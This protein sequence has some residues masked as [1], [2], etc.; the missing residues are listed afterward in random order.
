M[1]EGIVK[2]SVVGAITVPDSPAGIDMLAEKF[3]DV[4]HMEDVE[5][6]IKAFEEQ[7]ELLKKAAEYGSL[8]ARYA[9]LEAATY[10][11]LSRKG[12]SKALGAPNKMRR[13]AAEW[14]A[15]QEPAV[16]EMVING[17][18]TAKYSDLIDA[19]RQIQG[20]H[21]IRNAYKTAV[22]LKHDCVESFKQAG[23]VSVFSVWDH[24]V[25]ISDPHHD[26]TGE[27]SDN[28]SELD[29]FT[30]WVSRSLMQGQVGY[31]TEQMLDEIAAM[32]R[33][34]TRIA[35]RKAG[36]VG[37]G[38]GKYVDPCKYPE[39]VSKAIG[40]RKANVTACV[41]S[42]MALC[43]DAGVDFEHELA[44]ALS[45]VGWSKEKIVASID[46]TVG[47]VAA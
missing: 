10:C 36:A 4:M 22:N 46:R 42:L 32:A 34:S 16:Y 13:Q 7:D 28:D 31:R 43:K 5:N 2:A 41:M 29:C 9:S 44:E 45:M 18:L 20:E 1:G 39:E 37:I 23:M 6:V 26:P 25:C 24:G 15:A 21:A 8:R 33:D 30:P 35:L 3:A 47:G 14:L 40:I 11:K 19:Y 27:K 17:I 12:W 38:D